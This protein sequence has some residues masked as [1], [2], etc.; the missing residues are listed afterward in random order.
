MAEFG[1]SNV[2]LSHEDIINLGRVKLKNK[3]QVR[4]LFPLLHVSW[5]LYCMLVQSVYT[6][7]QS[8]YGHRRL[9]APGENIEMT[10]IEMQC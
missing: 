2:M 9:A 8:M 6:P 5:I 7:L 1:I 10:N 3:Q 4:H